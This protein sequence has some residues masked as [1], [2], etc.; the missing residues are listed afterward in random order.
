MITL[1]IKDFIASQ[2]VGPALA[3]ILNSRGRLAH[4]ALTDNERKMTAKAMFF[5]EIA[6]IFAV[7]SRK[8]LTAESE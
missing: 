7:M 8:H 6:L 3:H 5:K 2:G 1:N 4:T